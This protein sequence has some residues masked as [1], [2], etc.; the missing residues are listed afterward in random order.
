MVRVGAVDCDQHKDLA[1][2]YKIK[3]FPSIKIFASNK[4]EPIDYNG[5]LDEVCYGLRKYIKGNS[6]SRYC[7]LN[8]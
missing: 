5:M 1:A 7:N 4:K 8:L 3:G 2:T 6:F